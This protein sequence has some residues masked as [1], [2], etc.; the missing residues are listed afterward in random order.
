[1]IIKPTDTVREVAV[2]MP[3][4][5]RIFEKLGIDYCCGGNRTL[6]EASRAVRIPVE[7]VVRSLTNP[8]EPEAATIP[9]TDWQ[10][11][12]LTALTTFI[13]DQHHQFTRHELTRLQPLLKK[14]QAVHGQ[15]HSELRRLQELFD[16][17]NEDLTT[18]LLKEEQVLFPWVAKM[19]EAV[20]AGLPV[21]PPFFKTVRN[22]V[23]LM[24]A[25]HETVGD[26][27]REMRQVTSDYTV[28]PD[29]CFSYQ[30]LYQ[31]LLA[32]EADLHQHIHLENNILFPRAVAMEN[33]AEPE[34]RNDS[35]GNNIHGCFS[36]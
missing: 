30:T 12:S 18:H 17:L 29:G 36:H 14:V 33:S 11:E 25:E 34:A 16:H 3:N 8:P 23:R 5:T 31:G 2:I 13:V 19:E 1:M 15:N 20:S 27:L 6:A 35:T 26:L 4:A 21:P 9:L 28:P 32:L 10:Q 7:E 24:M 22:P